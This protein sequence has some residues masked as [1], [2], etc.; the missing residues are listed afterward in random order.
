MVLA[1]TDQCEECT[2]PS[3][4]SNLTDPDGS[5]DGDQAADYLSTSYFDIN[6]NK[7]YVTGVI[8]NADIA[9]DFYN[10]SGRPVEGTVFEV[11]DS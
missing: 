6:I 10:N 7:N 11:Q 2:V 8:Q 1:I 3:K 9:F 4:L 5:I